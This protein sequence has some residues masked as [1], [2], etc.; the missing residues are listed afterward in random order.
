MI[1]II[2]DLG[3]AKFLLTE[4]KTPLHPFCILGSKFSKAP[5]PNDFRMQIMIHL[6]EHLMFG[7]QTL[8]DSTIENGSVLPWHQR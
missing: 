6:H 8:S 3:N 1:E 7:I 2:A 5:L 4:L